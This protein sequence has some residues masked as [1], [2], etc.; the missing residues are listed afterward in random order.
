[1]SSNSKFALS[2]KLLLAAGLVAGATQLVSTGFVS[3]TIAPESPVVA[4][5]AL[6]EAQPASELIQ[7]SFE[8]PTAEEEA[9]F[10]ITDP[11]TVDG[12]M[13]FGEYAWN[14]EGVPAGEIRVIVDLEAERLYAYRGG[15]EIGRTVI[16]YGHDD[17]PTPTGS[18]TI[19]EKDED[20][21]SNL[22][23]VPMPYMMRLTNDGIAIH[24]S[25]V[26]EG[27]ASRGCIGVPDDF[28][29]LLF[30]Q[31]ELGTRVL[32]TR[33]SPVTDGNLVAGI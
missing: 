22:Y 25:M 11:L 7:A 21:I 9:G 16:L 5:V 17:S 29:E 28:A 30:N 3:T 26:E 6:P 1:M 4:S 14:E 27:F 19:T 18:F 13:A 32:I 12:E 23:F 24:G 15:S 31:V 8:E 33:G 20:H 10:R 2:F